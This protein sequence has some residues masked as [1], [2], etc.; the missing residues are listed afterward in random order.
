MKNLISSLAAIAAIITAAIAIYRPFRTARKLDRAIS[1]ASLAIQRVSS[2][3]AS[4]LE[5]ASLSA[6]ICLDRNHASVSSRNS[7][8]GCPC[9]PPAISRSTVR[10]PF[11][12]RISS[13]VFSIIIKRSLTL[14]YT[15][16][17]ILPFLKFRSP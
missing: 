7:D 9:C 11:D 17:Y 14:E 15:D 10:G 2:S 16:Q 6:S 3:R 1:L 12:S 8:L 13:R 5:E 4:R